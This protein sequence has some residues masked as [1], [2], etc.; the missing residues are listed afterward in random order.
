MRFFKEY[1]YL[2]DPEV[3]RHDLILQILQENN[4]VRIHR[5]PLL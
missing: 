4:F 2:L 5:S 1:N 3:R